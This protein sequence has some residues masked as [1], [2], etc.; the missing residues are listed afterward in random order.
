MTNPRAVETLSGRLISQIRAGSEE[1][2]NRLFQSVSTRLLAYVWGRIHSQPF[3]R[4]RIDSEDVFQTTCLLAFKGFD[5]FEYRRPG[6]FS[7]WTFTIARNEITNLH[8]QLSARH[9]NLGGER[10]LQEPIHRSAT[11]AHDLGDY[12]PSKLVTASQHLVLREQYE[13]TI[14][15]MRKLTP[16]QMTVILGRLYEEKS[17]G[18]IAEETGKTKG[19][20][21]ELFRRALDRMRSMKGVGDE[22]D[23]G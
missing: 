6:D 15:A 4:N 3:L 18:E 23:E 11:S 21:S 17:L 9:R 10:S 2:F 12:V 22:R 7:R 8:R 19:A 5:R 14:D 20:V 16:D 1:A 13:A